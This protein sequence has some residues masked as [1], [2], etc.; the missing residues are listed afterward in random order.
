MVINKYLIYAKDAQK[1]DSLS[2]FDEKV[3]SCV[4]VDEQPLIEQC[5]T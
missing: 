3:G 1:Y 4:F 2:W 5:K